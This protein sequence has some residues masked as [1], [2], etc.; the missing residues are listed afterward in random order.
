MGK[1]R[2]EE[3]LTLI[4]DVDGLLEIGAARVSDG[5][6]PNSMTSK[7]FRNWVQNGT[8]NWTGRKC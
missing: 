7:K 8:P 6:P 4:V 3:I 1:A 2:G 5:T